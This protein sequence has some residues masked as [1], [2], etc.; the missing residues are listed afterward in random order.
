MPIVAEIAGEDDPLVAL[1]RESGP[2]R[3]P[4]NGNGGSEASTV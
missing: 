2:A 1:V 4:G 3:L